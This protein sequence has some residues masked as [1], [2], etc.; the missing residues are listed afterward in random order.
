MFRYELTD[1]T[2]ITLPRFDS[3]K[4]GTIR[5]IRKLSEVDQ[6]FT[7]LE[8]LADEHTLAVIDELGQDEFQDLQ[9]AWFNHSGVDVGES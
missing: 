6:F 8:S 2:E 9:V 3:V 7:V 4:P 1:G 5:Q